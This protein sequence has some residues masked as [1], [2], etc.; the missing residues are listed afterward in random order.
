MDGS[1]AR[2]VGV[3]K[4]VDQHVR[5]G[6]LGHRHVLADHDNAGRILDLEAR[7]RRGRH[8]LAGRQ[9]GHRNGVRGE[10]NA[11]LGSRRVAERL[12]MA[13]G[14]E[15]VRAELKRAARLV[16]VAGEAVPVSE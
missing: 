4:V 1:S 12:V 5:D 10:V 8:G 14:G 7:D 9:L 13:L 11:R 16:V 15:D 6:T 3:A 2:G